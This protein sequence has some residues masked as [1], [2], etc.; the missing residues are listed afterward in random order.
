LAAKRRAL[1]LFHAAGELGHGRSRRFGGKGR[2]VWRLAERFGSRAATTG[3]ERERFHRE[4]PAECPRD[5]RC[6]EDE[7]ERQ[8]PALRAAVRIRRRRTGPAIAFPWR[9]HRHA[10]KEPEQRT[11]RRGGGQADNERAPRL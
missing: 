8:V 2:Q 11:Q 4:K 1:E 9:V 7:P 3:C 5:C 10:K 6:S